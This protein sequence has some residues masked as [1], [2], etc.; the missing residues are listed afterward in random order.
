MS[1][2]K[3]ILAFSVA[4]FI[5][6]APPVF[7]QSGATSSDTNESSASRSMHHAG[8]S[9]EGAVSNT[10]HAAK[11]AV[12]DTDITSRVK[13]ALHEDKTTHGTD[14][15]VDTIGGVV[16]LSGVAPSAGAADRAVTIAKQ[17]RGV[18]RVKNAIT[19]APQKSSM[20]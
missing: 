9:A 19:V 12:R 6:A 10:Y 18:Q 17:T 5:S 4:L 1:M 11:R 2:I 14:I 15:H 3:M 13:L 7:A 8:Q 20:R 16:T